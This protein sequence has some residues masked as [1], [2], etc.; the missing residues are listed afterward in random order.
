MQIVCEGTDP[1]GIYLA[2][3]LKRA[4]PS[5]QVAIVERP[6]PAALQTLPVVLTN[7]VKKRLCLADPV[8]QAAID[9]ACHATDRLDISRDGRSTLIEGIEHRFIA[10]GRLTL[11]ALTRARELGCE[12]VTAAP[13]ELDL[14]VIA[15]GEPRHEPFASPAKPSP[16]LSLAFEV[17][18]EIAAPAF[19]VR[20]T[21][22]GVF[23]AFLWP[24]AANAGVLLVETPVAVLEASGL[25]READAGADVCYRLFADDLG[26]LT[27]RPSDSFWRDRAGRRSPRWVAGNAVLIGDGALSAHPS[28]GLATRHA[29]EAAEDLAASFGSAGPVHETLSGWEKRR[30]PLAD[31]LARADAANLTWLAHVQRYIDM[32]PAQFAYA[33]STRTMRVDH[34]A[35]QRAD[36]AL[37]GAV[38]AIV[39]GPVRTRSNRPPPPMF[40]PIT[41]RSLT[42]PNRIVVSPM[43]MYNA[44]DGTVGDFHLVHYAS[45]ATG[46][47][48]LVLTE[49]ADVSPEGRIS[50]ACAGIYKP[51]HVPAWKRIVDYVHRHTGA[52]IGIQLGH[53]GRKGAVKRGWERGPLEPAQAWQTL[54]PSAIPFDQD[55]TTPRELDRDDMDRLI[56]AYVAAA[57][58]SHEAGFDIIEMHLAHGY[59]LSG[60]ISPLANKRSDAYGGSLANRLRFPMEVFEAVR[61]A[62]PADKPISTRISAFDWIEGGTTVED[63]VE[64]A[65]ALKAAGNDIVACS[66]GGVT[67][68][69]RPNVGRLYQGI[70]SD[71]V[72][73]EAKVATMTVGGVASHADANMMIAAGRADMCALARGFLYDPYFPLHAAQQQGYTDLDWPKEYRNA[74]ALRMRDLW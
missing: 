48:G 68:E 51:E 72:R 59:L 62:W 73:N 30:R 2:A 70:F 33:A 21:E 42:I 9:D 43:C 4:D 10:R 5:R 50:P 23:H 69:R 20:Q 26:G 29:M 56:A 19:L 74:T 61:A 60:F 47:A 57:R 45:R 63:A 13:D 12:V 14:L 46:G 44:D 52:T 64:I 37:T 58:M 35:M 39:A 7:Q 40:A 16:L 66:T 28:L 31:S 55:R 18:G 53:A 15:D 3:L 32:P 22:V 6:V 8:L 54:A 36:P 24:I 41:L 27:V 67:A 38:E 49:M 34:A 11:L 71:A 25:S 65:R 17:E 1:S